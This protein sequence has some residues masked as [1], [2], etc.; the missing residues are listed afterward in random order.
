MTKQPTPERA[1]Y[2]DG[3]Y[4]YAGDQERLCVCGHKLGVHTGEAPHDCLGPDLHGGCDCPRFK[5]AKPSR[6]NVR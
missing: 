1:R 3:R 6:Q 4:G 2:R 5:L